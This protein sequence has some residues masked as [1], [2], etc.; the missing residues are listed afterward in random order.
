MKNKNNKTAFT[1]IELTVVITIIA[2]L[3]SAIIVFSGSL[4]KN[5]RNKVTKDRIAVIYQAL[6]NFVK[7][8][9]RLP[10]PASLLLAK[11][12]TNYGIETGQPGECAYDS[13]VYEALNENDISYGMVPTEALGL[14]KDMAE[15]GFGNKLIY[16]VHDL[17]TIAQYP[18][19]TYADG[20]SFHKTAGNEIRVFSYPSTA[21]IDDV[22]LV[23]MSLGANGYGAFSA[24]STTQNGTTSTDSYE[25]ENYLTTIT[26]AA[27]PTVDTASYGDNGYVGRV[28]LLY[29]NHNSDVFDDIVFFKTRDN[30]F[31]DFDLYFLEGCTSSGENY[32]TTSY[33]GVEFYGQTLASSTACSSAWIYSTIECRY[34]DV[35]IN[36]Q[37]CP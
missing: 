20:F 17:H 30:L 18:D 7:N 28:A 1:L 32:S 22:V 21:T 14:H 27:S 25:T 35:W 31:A 33:S 4:F 2:V 10:C 29:E 16:V 24:I 19:A 9:Y 23:I 26:N 3:T 15:D 37:T 34:S 36:R 11:T 5:T 6:G 13:G 12:S 8:N